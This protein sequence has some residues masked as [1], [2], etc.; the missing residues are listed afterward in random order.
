MSP[1]KGRS[2]RISP[3]S[4][5]FIVSNT[6]LRRFYGGFGSPYLAHAQRMALYPG[7]RGIQAGL[8]MGLVLGS[9]GRK[10]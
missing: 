1:I 2:V 7:I 8:M 9:V 10:G 4:A 6:T 5:T 3:L